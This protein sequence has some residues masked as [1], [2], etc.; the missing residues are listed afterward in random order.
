MKY[1][2]ASV[3]AIMVTL[4]ALL[5]GTAQAVTVQPVDATAV[6]STTPP[7]LIS[8]G[9]GR[10]AHSGTV[11]VNIIADSFPN[12]LA[13]FQIRVSTL[14]PVIAGALQFLTPDFGLTQATSTADSI[15]MGVVDLNS[16]VEIGAVDAVLGTVTF[17]GRSEGITPIVIEVLKMSDED[18]SPILTS[19][20][21]GL[22][23]VSNS[24]DL[25]GDGLTE[26]INGNG[27]FDFADI[28]QLFRMLLTTP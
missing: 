27:F 28:L 7:T 11:Q 1:R 2:M 8:I 13:G 21:V 19:T 18:G 9:G 26:D 5:G 3:M 22:L 14:D 24:R 4:A 17:L 10:I 25:D 15:T 23:T 20:D 6:A 12:G 16:V